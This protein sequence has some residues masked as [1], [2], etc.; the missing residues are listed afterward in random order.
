MKGPGAVIVQS[1]N[2]AFV[3]DSEYLRVRG[4]RIIDG[5]EHSVFVEEE[6]MDVKRVIVEAYDIPEAL[7]AFGSVLA[8]P[9]KSIVVKL[10]PLRR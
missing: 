3:V 1:D 8:A 5:G 2:I 4:T 6:A 9:G 10:F 7:M